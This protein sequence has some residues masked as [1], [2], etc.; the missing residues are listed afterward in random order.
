MEYYLMYWMSWWHT[1]LHVISDLAQKEDILYLMWSFWWPCLVF[2]YQCGCW[3]LLTCKHQFQDYPLRM[4]VILLQPAW[5]TAI[6]VNVFY[7]FLCQMTN[8]YMNFSLWTSECH[9]IILW[10][11]NLQAKHSANTLYM[12]YTLSCASTVL[13]IFTHFDN[14]VCYMF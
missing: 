4:V 11:Y 14:N 5:P 10:L 12:T 6:H 8:T 7:T 9:T 2:A 3:Q 1:G 13:H